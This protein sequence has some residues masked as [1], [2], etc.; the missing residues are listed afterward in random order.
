MERLT[1]N[2]GQGV[3]LSSW[4]HTMHVNCSTLNLLKG[5]KW[6][7]LHRLLS[8]FLEPWS[9]GH[10]AKQVLCFSNTC[11]PLPG[12]VRWWKNLREGA[13]YF[14]WS[15]AAT[16]LRPCLQPLCNARLNIL[17]K[18][19]RCKQERLKNKQMQNI[20]KHLHPPRQREA[21]D[22]TWDFVVS[23]TWAYLQRAAL[24]PSVWTPQS[25]FPIVTI[26]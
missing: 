23:K 6:K 15:S 21:V 14:P 8:S 13:A 12:K 26:Y 25:S 4:S 22:D 3:A 24:F 17:Y 16:A 19:E 18:A 7:K 1:S 20:T 11:M 2:M 5:S 9:L 10:Y